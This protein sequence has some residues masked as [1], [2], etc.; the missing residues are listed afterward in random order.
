LLIHAA[1]MLVAIVLGFGLPFQGATP[2]P[3][4]DAEVFVGA[5][6]IASCYDDNDEA[7]AALLDEIDGTV[8]TL[9]DNAYDQGTQIEFAACYDPTWGRHL[10]RTRP[11]PGNHDYLTVDAEGYFGYFGEQ[12][13]EIDEGY[14]A[15]DLGAW[16][17]VALNT[18][19]SEIGGCGEGSAQ[20]EWLREDLEADGSPC[21][22][23]FMHH[24]RFSSA[25]HGNEAD[26]D[27]IWAEL[28]GHGV[29][30][31]LAGH[32]HT[33]ERFAPMDPQ[34][35][36]DP[37]TGIVQFVVGTGGA[38]LREIETVHPYSEAH[39]D[40]T[41]GVLQLTLEPDAYAWDFVPV[42][43]QSFDDRGRAACH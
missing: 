17:I 43:G 11:A 28:Y 40:S 26:L 34:G 5:G 7:T 35:N 12:A 29:E 20:L 25:G 8:F 39:N 33:Y 1:S 19:C 32:D 30:V 15:F 42:E 41:F 37:E 14:Y 24:P 18:N 16:H 23:A 13:G 21:T 2:D 10:D 9:G 27:A 3:G 4:S 31:V 36:P 22:L 38:P 6:D